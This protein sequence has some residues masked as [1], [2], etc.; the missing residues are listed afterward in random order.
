M[1]TRRT[2][3]DSTFEVPVLLIGFNRPEECRQ[4]ISSLREV[5]AKKVYFNVDGPRSNS[6]SDIEKVKKVRQLSNLFDWEC[7]L[8]IRFLDENLGCKLAISSGISWFFENVNEGIILEDDC[9]PNRD[10]YYFCE[11]MLEKYRYSDNVMHISGTSYLPSNIDY[12]H[13]HYFS[14]IHDV[15]GWATW[16]RAWD[17]F[18]LDVKYPDRNSEK[19]LLNNYFGSKKVANWFH[20]YLEDSK[21]TTC[22]LWSTYWSFALI[23]RNALSVAPI[24]NLVRNIGFESGATHGTDKS[25]QLYN[26]FPLKS[27]T[28]LPDPLDIRVSRDLD[29]ARFRL[30]RK[31]DPAL[32]FLGA[33]RIRIKRVPRKI[34]QFLH[35][36]DPRK[37]QNQSLSKTKESDTRC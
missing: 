31:T 10:F 24:V 4:V 22:T 30:I 12:D 9:L 21:S 35:D 28:N 8:H 33:L 34:S 11:R 29:R 16:K 2:K 19:V 23:T 1:A 26:R 27:L 5:G 36:Q 20:G 3:L 17:Y 37:L 14:A 6:Q 15:W 7:E 18:S 13:N 25:F 32:K